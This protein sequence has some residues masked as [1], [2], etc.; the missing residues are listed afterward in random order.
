MG[1][2][3]GGHRLNPV[4]LRRAMTVGWAITNWTADMNIAAHPML[5]VNV[6]WESSF[7]TVHGPRVD[8]CMESL[9]ERKILRDLH[10]RCDG[11]H[12]VLEQ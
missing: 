10:K 12:M 4:Q 6:R 8:C 11:N 3:Y 2:G 1:Q 5:N 7:E 9:A